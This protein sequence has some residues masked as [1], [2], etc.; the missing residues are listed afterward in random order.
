MNDIT[1][2]VINV[3]S[4]ATLL[5]VIKN[6]LITKNINN[7]LKSKT[8]SIWPLSN[9]RHN[10]NYYKDSNNNYINRYA[11]CPPKP[12]TKTILFDF[13]RRDFIITNIIFS[14]RCNKIILLIEGISIVIATT[15]PPAKFGIL[16]NIL[17]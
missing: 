10:Y 16:P 8:N 2:N 5:G 7:I 3:F 17:L 11:Q 4:D 13:N 15:A 1:Q 14:S 12:I 6:S 9:K